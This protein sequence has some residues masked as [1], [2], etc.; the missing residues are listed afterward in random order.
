MSSRS[1]VKAASEY[2][3]GWFSAISPADYKIQQGKRDKAEKFKRERPEQF[4][5]QLR[6][7]YSEPLS[8]DD[9]G[10][11]KEVAASYQSRFAKMSK[12]EQ[13]EAA[14][15]TGRVEE[16]FPSITGEMMAYGAGAQSDETSKAFLDYHYL[17]GHYQ[18]EVN[19]EK[20]YECEKDRYARDCAKRGGPGTFE[21]RYGQYRAH[22]DRG[23][24]MYPGGDY[25]WYNQSE[26]E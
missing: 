9:L 10:D 8:D 20:Y 2:R 21:Q 12:G 13:F 26:D 11:L 17:L 18:A 5:F 14:E 6:R 15:V 3:A 22:F 24:A 25:E 23:M 16:H 4:G 7:D 1:S 19:E